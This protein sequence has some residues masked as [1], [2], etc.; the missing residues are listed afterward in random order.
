MLSN[1]LK[2][3][4]TRH[5]IV[6]V[7]LGVATA[8]AVIHYVGFTRSSRAWVIGFYLLSYGIGVVLH[9]SGHAAAALVTGGEVNYMRLGFRITK[10]P[11]WTIKFLGFPILIY[12]LPFSGSVQSLVYST[13]HY[14][15]KRCFMIAAGVLVNTLL[16]LGGIVLIQV[17]PDNSDHSFVLGWMLANALLIAISLFP[18]KIRSC[19]KIQGNDAM[20]FWETLNYSDEKIEQL[21]NSAVLT[22][23]MKQGAADAEKMSIPE[24]LTK[25]EAE[26]ANSAVL[27]YLIEKLR[28]ADDPRHL[29]YLLKLIELPVPEST[30]GEFIDASLTRQLNGGPPKRPELADQ[31]SQRLLKINDCISTRGTRGSVLVD[32]GRTDEGW[33][34][35]QHVLWKTASE[36]DQVYT[37]IFLALAESQRG[38]LAVAREH[39]GEAKRIDPA[40]PALQR[41]SDL[42]RA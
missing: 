31:L 8:F 11:P 3:P 28:E 30:I 9:E 41:V 26:P 23:T 1:E 16:L 6:S 22:R 33:T 24:L 19:G 38:N 25:Q 42:L 35:L 18:R 5:D 29:D 32:L 13:H 2:R 4:V 34:M 12:G 20:N 15:T 10:R 40:C 7:I 17:L 36:F 14:R 21:I 37:H 27:M 39:A